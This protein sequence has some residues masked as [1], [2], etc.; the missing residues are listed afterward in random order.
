MS[1]ESAVLEKLGQGAP[2]WLCRRRE[3]AWDVY[4]STPL[5]TTRSEEWRYTDLSQIVDLESLRFLLPGDADLNGF[6]P[7]ILEDIMKE[8]WVA[9]GSSLLVDGLTSNIDLEADLVAQGVI[10]TSLRSAAEDYSD[11]LEEHLAV[12]ALPPEKG[13]FEALNAA[14]WTDGVLLYI[15]RDVN[16]KLPLRAV[17]YFSHAGSA[18]CTRTL[19]IAEAGSQVSYVEEIISEDFDEITL[20]SSSLEVIAKE[21]A[22][23]QFVSIQQ[24][25]HGVFC[26]SAQRTLAHRDATLNTLNVGP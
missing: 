20:A 5:P 25:G 14:F 17:N 6:S 24:S 9:S 19:I 26:Q 13:K 7:E 22:K 1:L 8:N 16:I 2:D 21:G 23:V 18:V 15:P 12:E 3:H 10:F 4:K 11:L